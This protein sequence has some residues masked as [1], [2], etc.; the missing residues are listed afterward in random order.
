ALPGATD[1]AFMVTNAQLA[2]SGSYSVTVTNA[3]GLAASTL[4]TLTVYPSPPLITAQPQS[5]TV[6][7]G[8]NPVFS[9]TASGDAP[10]VYLWHFN[11]TNAVLDATNSTFTI[12]NAQFANAGS[13]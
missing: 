10:L 6:P 4:A 12:T 8:A 1:F 5:L 9:V 11:R 3:Y 2:N 7:I 13:Y